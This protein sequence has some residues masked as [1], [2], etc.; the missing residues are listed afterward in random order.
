MSP[1]ARCFPVDK[2]DDRVL[3]ENPW[4]RDMLLR[5]SPA[6]DALHHVTTDR[7]DAKSGCLRL[8]IRDSYINFYH[9]GQSV[10]QVRFDRNGTL[11]AKIHNKFVL[12]ELGGGQTYLTLTCDGFSNA[13]GSLVRPYGGRDDL[14]MLIKN[15]SGHAG[16][17]KTFVDLI[18]A[19]N[20]NAIDLEMALPAYLDD[21]KARRA[22]RMDLVA[23]ERAGDGWQIVFWEAKLAADGRLRCEGEGL[24]KVVTQQL[25]DYKDWLNYADHSR[26]VASAYQHACRLL[27][28]FHGLAKAI[29]PGLE[30]LGPGIIAVAAAEAPSLRVD[31]DPRLLIDN[32]KGT[33]SLEK[34]GHLKKLRDNG[35]H[36]Q[37][38][39]GLGDMALETHA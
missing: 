37:M 15:A 10:A 5:W 28:G 36:V 2:I 32:R 23:L 11:R 29:N 17:E 1:F 33:G 35:I 31:A 38:V 24:P 4:F 25:K 21:P 19:R 14:D 30:E 9:N 8:A 39:S 3:A 7:R 18:V 27:V 16:D 12:G 22:P 13:G 6:G 26:A 34:N 20:S